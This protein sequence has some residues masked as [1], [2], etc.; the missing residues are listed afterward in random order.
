MHSFNRY[1]IF[2]YVHIPK[3]NS[4]TFFLFNCYTLMHVYFTSNRSRIRINHLWNCTHTKKTDN[5]SC[6]IRFQLKYFPQLY[7]TIGSNSC[8]VEF[9]FIFKSETPPHLRHNFSWSSDGFTNL[10]FKNPEM[11]SPA[12]S[13]KLIFV[14]NQKQNGKLSKKA[15][16]LSIKLNN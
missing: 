4:S 2:L 15:K 10:V 13:S 3:Y 5:R 1:N 7:C 12:F 11:F 9:C 6:K 16:H 14:W 8:E